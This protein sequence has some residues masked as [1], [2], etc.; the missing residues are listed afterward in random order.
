MS[1]DD[2]CL[3]H[4]RDDLVHVTF[5]MVFWEDRPFL[6]VKL[7]SAI[8]SCEVSFSR[9]I[10]LQILNLLPFLAFLFVPVISF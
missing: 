3:G 10:Y 5:L 6:G 1:I 2:D 8:P 4:I 9:N 7:H